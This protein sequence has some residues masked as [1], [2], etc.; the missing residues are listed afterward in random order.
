M[1][2]V[3][4]YTAYIYILWQPHAIEQGPAA[5]ALAPWTGGGRKVPPPPPSC[6]RGNINRAQGIKNIGGTWGTRTEKL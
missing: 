5:A 3:Y 2:R 6:A 1:N 4:V